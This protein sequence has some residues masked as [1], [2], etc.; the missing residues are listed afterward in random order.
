MTALAL[1]A[2]FAAVT[3]G[4]WWIVFPSPVS[5]AAT[6]AALGLQWRIEY[7]ACARR[8][9]RTQAEGGKVR[10]AALRRVGYATAITGICAGCIVVLRLAWA[11]LVEAPAP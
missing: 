6:V 7:I 9:R 5:F 10:F 11:L 4:S 1:L 2:M 3:A 8:I